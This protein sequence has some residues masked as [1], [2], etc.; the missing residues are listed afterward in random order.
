MTSITVGITSTKGYE[1]TRAVASCGST[2]NRCFHDVSE[3][4]WSRRPA[5]RLA[6]S[7]VL[8]VVDP[9]KP[10]QRPGAWLQGVDSVLSRDE[11]TYPVLWWYR[12]EAPGTR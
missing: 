4:G 6:Y 2:T 5:Q 12:N 1:T 3:S 9:A 11:S 7:L 8:R 10:R